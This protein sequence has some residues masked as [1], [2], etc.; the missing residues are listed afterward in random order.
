MMEHVLLRQG[1]DICLN[2]LSGGE[3]VKVL[4]DGGDGVTEVSKKHFTKYIK[5]F[6][7][8]ELTVRK[9]GY[10]TFELFGIS[11]SGEGTLILESGFNCGY[12]GEGP[13]GALW[14]IEK[15]GR[16]TTQLKRLITSCNLVVIDFRGDEPKVDFHI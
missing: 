7:P 4:H 8:V 3:R 5:Y 11:K 1:M 6:V 2:V 12:G 15:L 10:F 14:A 13:H 16:V 9:H